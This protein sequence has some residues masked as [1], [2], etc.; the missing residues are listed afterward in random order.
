M[1]FIAGGMLGRQLG[2]R[3][4]RQPGGE[5]LT[6][7][8]GHIVTRPRKL[9]QAPAA[10]ANH[11]GTTVLLRYPEQQPAAGANERVPPASLGR[12]ISGRFTHGTTMLARPPTIK[13]RSRPIVAETSGFGL[14][15]PDSGW[16]DEW[17]RGKSATPGPPPSPQK[18]SLRP[19]H[20]NVVLP[21]RKRS[22][23]RA[24]PRP[25]LIA[26]TTRLCP[27]RMSPATNTPSTLVV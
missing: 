14:F 25:S 7:Q 9:Q 1:T 16:S 6:D 17:F 24:A 2:H 11:P 18:G 10:G 12:G 23:S 8:R 27:R 13:P 20:G 21:I 15:R 3:P 22:H 4:G 19:L 5:C 26:Q